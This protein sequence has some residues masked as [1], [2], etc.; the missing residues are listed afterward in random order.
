MAKAGKDPHGEVAFIERALRRHALSP[1]GTIL[2]A[3]CGTGRV[4]IELAARGHLVEGTDVDE[5]ML[6]HARAKAPGLSW[7]LGSLAT[8]SF[9]TPFSVVAMAGNVIL[10]VEPQDRPLV[11]PNVAGFIDDGGLLIAGFQL[12]RGDGRRVAVAEWDRWAEQAHLGL[13]ERFS[14]WDEDEFTHESD[15]VVNVHRKAL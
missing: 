9:A 13:V 6:S 4:A 10:F 12:S 7:T 15:Y 2:D 1:G 3:G 8:I 5:V 11:I 14:T